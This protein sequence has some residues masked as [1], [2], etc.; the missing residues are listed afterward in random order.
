MTWHALLGWLVWRWSGAVV[1]TVGRAVLLVSRSRGLARRAV[2]LGRLAWRWVATVGPGCVAG[3]M[4]V[5]RSCAP[6]GGVGAVGVAVERRGG[7]R[8]RGQAMLLAS[9]RSRGLARRVGVATGLALWA[10][11][12]GV[13]VRRG[14]DERK[15][16]KKKKETLNVMTWLRGLSRGKVV[17]DGGRRGPRADMWRN[18]GAAAA[19]SV[20]L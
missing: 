7:W 19:V 12:V 3:V 8:L 1:A 4:A 18:G 13:T 2:A 5:A 11:T 9:R 20:I 16:K 6:C 17:V 10:C 14:G 15:K